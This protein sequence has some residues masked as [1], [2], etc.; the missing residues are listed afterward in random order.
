MSN[1]NTP[2]KVKGVADII[3]L[4]DATGSMQPGIDNLKNNIEHFFDLLENPS[5]PNGQLPV[6]DWRAAVYA[7]RDYAEDGPKWFEPRPFVRGAAAVKAQL[8]EIKADGGGD[9]PEDL[10]DALLKIADMDQTPKHA[11]MED[12][13]KWRYAS[14]A[15]RVVI[16][17]TDASFHMPPPTQPAATIMD[18]H[19]K[20]CDARLLLY[21]FVPD[22]MACYDDEM[23]KVGGCELTCFPVAS[24]ENPAKALAAFT[25]DKT[26]FDTIL[27][28]LAKS[29][30]NSSF[31]IPLS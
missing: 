11:Q 18:L 21:L 20:V 22:G 5:G 9:E 24:G 4:V 30:S 23:S 27:E 15:A 2:H 12:P 1:E 31:N 29:I 26:K 3:F 7:Y 10:V 6:K 25:S 14:E 17:M 16:V 19:N 28:Q 8:A 13:E